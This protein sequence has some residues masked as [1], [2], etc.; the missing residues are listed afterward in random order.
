MKNEAAEPYHWVCPD[1]AAHPG[2]EA[3]TRFDEQHDAAGCCIGVEQSE[4]LLRDILHAQNDG[5]AERAMRA[6]REW[7]KSRPVDLSTS[8]QDR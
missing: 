3:M 8:E 7:M 4:R 5:E 6:A 1:P 2:A